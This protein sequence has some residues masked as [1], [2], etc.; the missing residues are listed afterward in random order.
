M[1]RHQRASAFLNVAESSHQRG[2]ASTAVIETDTP[3]IVSELTPR[4]VEV[5]SLLAAG[6]SNGQIADMLVITRSTAEVHV[7]RV[8]HRDD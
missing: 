2:T 8:I 7:K 1:K 5:A 3:R 4:E 6:M